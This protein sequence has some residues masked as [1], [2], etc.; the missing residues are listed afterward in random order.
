MSNQHVVPV[1]LINQVPIRHGKD[2]TYLLAVATSGYDSLELTKRDKV[3][4]KKANSV[5]HWRA[6]INID[7]EAYGMYFYMSKLHVALSNC[8]RLHASGGTA[9]YEHTHRVMS[10]SQS[11]CEARLVPT[12]PTETLAL[13]IT[14]K[15]SRKGG[16]LADCAVLP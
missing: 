3:C 2:H 6:P 14:S 1:I 10:P 12:R 13:N 9:S 8:I 11:A 15:S 4:A 7:R 5:Q 16:V